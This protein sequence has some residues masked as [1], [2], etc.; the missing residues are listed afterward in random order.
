M[1]AV[2]AIH[3]EPPCSA[4]GVT[5]LAGSLGS[6]AYHPPDKHCQKLWVTEGR[7]Q[8]RVSHSISGPEGGVG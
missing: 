8:A 6:A 2:L 5:L 7:H 3:S 1:E 4:Y